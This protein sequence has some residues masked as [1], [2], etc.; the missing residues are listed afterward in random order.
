MYVFKSVLYSIGQQ[1]RTV[2]YISK[3]VGD[4]SVSNA[5]NYRTDDHSSILRRSEVFN[6]NHRHWDLL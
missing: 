1:V 6:F 4:N 2:I 3:M 5:T